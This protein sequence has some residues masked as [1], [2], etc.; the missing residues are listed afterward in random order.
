MAPIKRKRE[1]VAKTFEW[2]NPSVAE[3]LEEKKKRKVLETNS[4]S[5]SSYAHVL[6]IARG[7]KIALYSCA[8][9][10]PLWR[11]RLRRFLAKNRS[12]VKPRP[13]NTIFF[14]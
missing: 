1:R 5:K 2:K 12:K 10:H 6:R 7:P 9:T 11:D 13:T 4:Q 8:H 3:K 14:I